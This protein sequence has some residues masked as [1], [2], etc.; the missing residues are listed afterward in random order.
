M[1]SLDKANKERF[2]FYSLAH[3]DMLRVRKN[4]EYFKITTDTH[5]LDVLC[6]DAIVNY[7]K[8]FTANRGEFQKNGLAVP[9]SFVPE[10]LRQ[11]HRELIKIRNKLLAHIDLSVQAAKPELY[12]VNGE[13]H[14]AFTVKGYELVDLSIWMTDLEKLASAVEKVL[15]NECAR[16]ESSLF[17][18]L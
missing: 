4:A 2:M 7:C 6:R 8:P 1:C 11:Q 5:L 3:G 14:F 16:L 12:E 17:P 10:V 15:L 9:E 18:K 13:N